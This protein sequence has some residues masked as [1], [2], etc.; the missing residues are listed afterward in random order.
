MS[1]FSQKKTTRYQ[2]INTVSKQSI[3][4][5]R[6]AKDKIYKTKNR[7][8][9]TARTELISSIILFEKNMNTLKNMNS[10]KDIHKNI[11]RIELQWLGYKKSILQRAYESDKRIM[12]F[13]DII[14]K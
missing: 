13:N 9:S 4:S 11:I 8:N 5:Q 6:M 7:N 3:L 12:S 2:A 10:R 1:V 14:L